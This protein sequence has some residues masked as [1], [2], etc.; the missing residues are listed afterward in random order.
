MYAWG[1]AGA[2]V[3]AVALAQRGLPRRHMKFMYIAFALEVFGV[4]GYAVA[5]HPWHAMV[6]SFVTGVCATAGMVVWGTLTQ[7]LVPAHLLGRVR[8]V[9]WLI[10]IGLLPVSFAVTGPVA[11]AIGAQTTLI[12]CGIIGGVATLAFMLI[13][14][15]YATEHDG[16]VAT[17][18]VA[19]AEDARDE[20]GV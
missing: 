14:G 17:S 2:I 9:D 5:T 15:L 10:S 19:V 6:I 16:S 20:V 13:P 1:G 18:L 3:A 4:A 11:D 8:S 7:T 12:A